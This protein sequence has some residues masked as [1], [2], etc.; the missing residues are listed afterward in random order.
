MKVQLVCTLIGLS[1]AEASA[2]KANPATYGQQ[3]CVMLRSGITQDK[4]WDYIVRDHTKATMANPQMVIPWYSAASAGWALGTALGNAELAQKKLVAMKA[5]VL[6]VAR[7]TCP[8]Q[9]H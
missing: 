5:D 1:V 7:S 9:F 3:L 6:R 8:E 4:A 2:A